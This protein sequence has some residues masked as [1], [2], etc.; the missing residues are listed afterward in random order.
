MEQYD[1]AIADFKTAMEQA[2]SEGSD[3]DVRALKAEVD[4]KRSR[5]SEGEC[6]VPSWLADACGCGAVAVAVVWIAY[7]RC[8]LLSLGRIISGFLA[9][10]VM[11]RVIRVRLVVGDASWTL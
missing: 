4:L 3:A 11:Q 7:P 8:I 5:E 1:A 2:E 10:M 6:T 9:G